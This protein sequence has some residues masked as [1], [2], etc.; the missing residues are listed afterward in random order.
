M[1][2]DSDFD[3]KA[4]THVR[5]FNFLVKALKRSFFYVILISKQNMSPYPQW[6]S[7]KWHKTTTDTIATTNA[8][9]MASICY[10]NR[11]EKKF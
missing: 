5:I 10:D 7:I 2:G 6:R 4:L 3:Y 9:S 8:P 11:R 1:A